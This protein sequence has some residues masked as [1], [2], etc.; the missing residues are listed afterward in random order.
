M[1][2]QLTVNI[3]HRPTMGFNILGA[4]AF[5]AIMYNFTTNGSLTLYT[6]VDIGLRFLLPCLIAG[7]CCCRTTYLSSTRYLVGCVSGVS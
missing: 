2:Y 4:G 3:T 1:K 7:Y 5:C 6:R